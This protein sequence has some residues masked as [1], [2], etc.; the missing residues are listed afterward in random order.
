MQGLHAGGS[1]S[2]EVL[3]GDVH[4]VLRGMPDASF[5]GLLSDPPYGL[6]FM[7]KKWDH[8][9][10]K[11]EVWQEALRVLKPG[12]H[13]LAF[14]GTR[15]YHRLVCAIE[16]AGFEIRDCISWVYFSG[17]PKNLDVSKAIDAAAVERRRVGHGEGHVAA[18]ITAPAT[19]E[20][21]RFSGYGTALKPAMELVVVA[22]KPLDGT[23][24]KNVQ[25]HG[26][27][28]LNIDGGRI[29]FASM[30]DEARSKE[31]NQHARHGNGPKASHGIY[32]DMSQAPRPNYNATGRW[33]SN[34]ILSHAEG[35]LEVGTRRVAT[36]KAHRTNG[37]GKTFGGDAEKPA[38]ADMTYADGDGT[39]SVESWACV[40]GCPVAEMDR[41]SGERPGMSGGGVHADGYGGG[42]FGGIDSAGTARGDIGGG[43]RFLYVAKASRF[44][45]EFG[46]EHLPA[47]AGFEAVDREEGTAG[48]TPR[49]G[50]GRTAEK[51]RNFGPCVKPISLARYLATLILP[52]DHCA[53]RR[54]VVPYC[55]TGSEM[56]GALRAGWDEVIGIQRASDDDERGYIAIAR[57]RL[58]RWDEVPAHVEP[59]E[60]KPEVADVRQV[61][62]FGGGL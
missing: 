19:E 15:T 22:R 16:D 25:E 50:A 41:Q 33:P 11:V 8:G 36:G 2:W 52:P 17:F 5:S 38:L 1:V 31:K 3:E 30:G 28:A 57:A 62:L 45:R 55:G 61:G 10:P 27:G 42:M 14:G 34:V 60:N 37:G 51:V 49:S 48:L 21:A 54:L 35:C 12:A 59:T 6:K 53:P 56:I 13:L 18:Q 39:E 46:C 24:A 44:E 7:G 58:V 23:V 29:G 4:D 47:R 43:S 32:G 40:A 20:A 9:V 26:T